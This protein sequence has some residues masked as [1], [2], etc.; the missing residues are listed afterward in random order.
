MTKPTYRI[1]PDV[2]W[3]IVDEELF[4]VTP[5]GNL[6]HVDSPTGVYVWHLLDRKPATLAQCADAVFR[7]FEVDLPTAS[8]DLAEFLGRLVSLGILVEA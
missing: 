4:A 1:S 5:D 7:E 2:A 8:G 6:H 3:R